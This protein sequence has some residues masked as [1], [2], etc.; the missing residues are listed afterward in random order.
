M[1][2]KFLDQ[3]GPDDDSLLCSWIRDTVVLGMERGPAIRE[4]HFWL[5]PDPDA[6]MSGSAAALPDFG[7]LRAP[8]LF[9]VYKIA[10]HIEEQLDKEQR[11]D[12]HVE[13]LCRGRL[14]PQKMDIGSVQ[15]FHWKRAEDMELV[16]RV[17]E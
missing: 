9:R 6:D 2:S 12:V 11:A 5:R 8:R 16:F 13:V 15:R 10:A 17:V 1:W 4:V 7:K 3:L 14:L